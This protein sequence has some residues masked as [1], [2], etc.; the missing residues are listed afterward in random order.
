[1]SDEFNIK[2]QHLS[3][4]HGILTRYVSNLAKVIDKFRAIDRSFE[5][6]IL[7][8]GI[9]YR[10]FNMGVDEYKFDIFTPTYEVKLH[11]G[12]MDIRYLYNYENGYIVNMHITPPSWDYINIVPPLCALK[13][14]IAFLCNILESNTTEDFKIADDNCIIVIT[15]DEILYLS[16]TQNENEDT[17]LSKKIYNMIYS[18]LNDELSIRKNVRGVDY[19]DGVYTIRV[20]GDCAMQYF[21]HINLL[22]VITSNSFDLYTILDRIEEV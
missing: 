13:G 10:G 5:P 15:K 14:F 20:I 7:D 1:M 18:L 8:S 16:S 4:P 19:E 21:K 9:R 2:N 17:K 3:F 6:Y 22:R 12:A 11:Y